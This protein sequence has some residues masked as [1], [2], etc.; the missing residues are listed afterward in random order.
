[1]N[2]SDCYE[3][4]LKLFEVHG[5]PD[6]IL[7]FGRAKRQFGYAHYSKKEIRLSRHLVSLNTWKV[8]EQT[9]LH[10]IAHAL[11]GRGHGH[12]KVWKQ[13]AIELGDDGQ[14]CYSTKDVRTV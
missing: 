11:V 12:D 14:R 1:M 8:V 3:K 13:K 5:I 6:W 9:V 7:K 10:E 4:T 2:L